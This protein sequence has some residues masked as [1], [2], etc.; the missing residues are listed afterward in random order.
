[1]TMGQADHDAP[2]PADFVA[3]LYEGLLGRPADAGGRD[4]KA[5]R[6]ASG[7]ATI[8]D[9][10]RQM[11][12]SDEF[13][14]KLPVLLAQSPAAA[15]RRLT[16]DVSQYGEIW[17]LIRF[18]AND[19]VPERFVV[20]IGAR[21]LERSNSYDLVRHFGWR[22]L[23]IEAN[24]QLLPGL[25]SAFAGLDAQLLCCAVS[26][27]TGQATFTLGV[28]DDVSSL[29]SNVAADWGPTRGTMQVTVRRLGDILAEAGVSSDFGLLSLDIEGED[30]KVLN[31]L[32]G[33]SPFRPRWV[34]I[35]ASNDFSV[36]SLDDAPFSHGVKDA[37]LLRGQTR[38]NLILQRR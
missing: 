11:L 12:L 30:I 24:D 5:A 18:W 16:N 13:I 4:E 23:L 21:G 14:E 10:C 7:E 28:N 3:A 27:Y 22:A 25:R 15:R 1:M 26:D 33:T 35:E 19:A 9:I 17:E 29:N 20:D 34:I 32:I 6:I 2:T 8:V 38:S 31:D 36:T 37:Y